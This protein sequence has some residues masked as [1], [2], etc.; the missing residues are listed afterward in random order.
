MGPSYRLRQWAINGVCHRSQHPCTISEWL[1]PSA[2]VN[3]TSC[4]ACKL[5]T[6]YRH[7]DM[8]AIEKEKPPQQQACRSCCHSC[9]PMYHVWTQHHHPGLPEPMEGAFAQCWFTW[10]CSYTQG[11]TVPLLKQQTIY[12]ES[13]KSYFFLQ[14]EQKLWEQLWRV[15]KEITGLFFLTAATN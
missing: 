1:T 7:L 6:A 14:S 2:L 9:I 3:V 5:Q 4:S 15:H 8:Q 12:I 11:G 13:I 10:L